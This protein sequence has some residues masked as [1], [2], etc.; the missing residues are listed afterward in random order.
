MIDIPI[1]T[2][3]KPGQH[4]GSIKGDSPGAK[5]ARHAMGLLYVAEGKI[6]DLHSIVKGRALL[7]Q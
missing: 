5:T 4:P 3:V 7:H 1:H 2:G 6:R